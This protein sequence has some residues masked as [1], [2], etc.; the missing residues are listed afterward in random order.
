MINISR[1]VYKLRSPSSR[2]LA[3]LSTHDFSNPTKDWG[4]PQ[5]PFDNQIQTLPACIGN[6]EA[7]L[8]KRVRVH[9]DLPALL[10]QVG[11]SENVSYARLNL[12]LELELDPLPV[13]GLIH[14]PPR[15]LSEVPEGRPAAVDVGSE[16]VGFVMIQCKHGGSVYRGSAAERRALDGGFG[17]GPG[18]MRSADSDNSGPS[19]PV[20][21]EEAAGEAL[22]ISFRVGRYARRTLGSV[23]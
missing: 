1:Q 6:C 11:A 7:K 12:G 17:V 5:L 16:G 10:D 13:L 19:S 21:V 8:M 9:K 4:F 15:V 2:Y 20:S 22:N 18:Q 3:S 14:R 23:G